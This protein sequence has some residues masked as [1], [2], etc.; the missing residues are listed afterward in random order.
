MVKELPLKGGEVALVDDE[1]YPLLS[2]Y[3]W[4]QAGN[5]GYAVTTMQTITGKNHTIYLHKLVVGGFSVLDHINLDPLDCRKENLRRATPQEN[6]WNKGKP[7]SCRHGKSSSQFKGV[8]MAVKVDGTPY[9]GVIIKTSKKG[10]VPNRYVRLGPFSTEIEAA[11]A[12]N[13]KIVELRG[14]WA[15]VNPIPGE[16]EVA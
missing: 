13:A 5:A 11:K 10:E 16:T 8:Q 3:M 6:G 1:D 2:R 9:W 4:Q 14:E 7:R 15:W 12:Y